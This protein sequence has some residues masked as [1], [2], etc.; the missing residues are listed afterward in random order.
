[1]RRIKY[2]SQSNKVG[3]C[4]FSIFQQDSL[5]DAEIIDPQKFIIIFKFL[6]LSNYLKMKNFDWT[7][8]TRKIAISRPVQALYDA[9][10]KPQDLERWFLSDATFL[11]LHGTII[12]KLNPINA[13]NSYQW[14][15]HLYP[16]TET[17]TVLLANG[18]D[19]IQFTFAGN[20]IIDV[21]FM[22]Y[23][24]GT[25]VTL[26]QKEIPTDDSSKLNVRLGCDTGW[27]FY[28][29]NL[30]SVYEGGLDLRNKNPLLKGMLNS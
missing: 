26:S 19:H 14:Q 12:P 15:W 23:E 27:S 13:G 4:I 29:V 16:D 28:L 11:D 1:M 21:Y 18:H 25:V 24:D 9:W 22:A 20:C 2:K 17:G 30:K 8:F 7:Q 3:F 6:K 10:S 5:Q